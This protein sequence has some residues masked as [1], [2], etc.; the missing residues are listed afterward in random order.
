MTGKF[1]VPTEVEDDGDVAGARELFCPEDRNGKDAFARYWNTPQGVVLQSM[2]SNEDVRGRTM[3]QWLFERYG[4]TH[5]R[6]GSSVGPG[7]L[8]TYEAGRNGPAD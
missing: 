6:R 7:I 5:H 3:I 2:H 4:A 1:F 8:A